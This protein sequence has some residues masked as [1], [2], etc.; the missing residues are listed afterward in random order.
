MYC[1]KC[2]ARLCDTVLLKD[3][4]GYDWP[5]DL[6]LCA[7]CRPADVMTKPAL[8]AFLGRKIEIE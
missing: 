8:E 2:D 6:Q 3:E 7:D 4:E 1:Q 5:Y